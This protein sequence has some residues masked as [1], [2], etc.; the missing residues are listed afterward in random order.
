MK[1]VLLGQQESVVSARAV[2]QRLLASIFLAGLH[3]I[4]FWV[5]LKL[6]P[7]LWFF[8]L[9]ML[10]FG[11]YFAAKSYGAIAGRHPA[12]YWQE[13]V[14]NMLILLG[15]AIE[16]SAAGRDPYKAFAIRFSLFV[17]I[18]LYAWGAI[19]ALERWRAHRAGATP[20]PAILEGGR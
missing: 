14:V 17:V 2:G 10:L 5:A 11:M 16:D 4:L 12:T 8:F 15:P 7:S 9:L 18:T 19:I 6:F 13:V 1:A 20:G 3:A